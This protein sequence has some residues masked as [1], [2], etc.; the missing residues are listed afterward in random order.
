MISTGK[1]SSTSFNFNWITGII[2][3]SKLTKFIGKDTIICKIVDII[4]CGILK[5]RDWHE[6]YVPDMNHTCT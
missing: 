6:T 2:L 5:D 4:D 1:V 3:T